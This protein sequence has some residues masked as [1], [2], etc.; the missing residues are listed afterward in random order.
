MRIF[1]F[2]KVGFAILGGFIFLASCSKTLE[3][4]QNKNNQKTKKLSVLNGPIFHWKIGMQMRNNA[5]GS[6]FW[7]GEV[8]TDV[9]MQTPF[10]NLDFSHTSLMAVSALGNGAVP[11]HAIEGE[12]LGVQSAA[13]NP[14]IFRNPDPTRINVG[15]TLIF[16]LGSAVSNYWMRGCRIQMN[17][18]ATTLGK[19]EFWRDGNKI[20][21]K[22]IISPNPSL[23][24]VFEY[25]SPSGS[26][27]NEIRLVATNGAFQINARNSN[28]PPFLNPTEFYIIE[29]I[30]V[31]P[32]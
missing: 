18:N 20:N 14:A 8:R 29:K 5:K 2:Q 21:E 27:F 22:P 25:D 13:D 17:G 7:V 26:E 11:K 31:S 30:E 24:F 10:S 16:K 28:P 9:N 3:E 19:A 15:E 32:F 23:N 4:P 6:Y 1:I 12:H